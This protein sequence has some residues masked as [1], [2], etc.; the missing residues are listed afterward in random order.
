M[1]VYF[2]M[3]RP[4]NYDRAYEADL[5]SRLAPKIPE[6]VFDAHFHISRDEIP[7]VPDAEAFDTWKEYTNHFLGGNRI[8]GG[9]VMAHPKYYAEKETLDSHRLFACQLAQEHEGF[10]SGLVIRP[11]DDP[12]E[13][14]D[15]IRR[16]PRIVALKPYLTYSGAENIYEA[17]L[18]QYAPEWMWELASQY[19]LAMVLHLSHFGDGLSDPRNGEQLR[20]LCKKYPQVKVNL[21]HCAMGHNPD[22]LQQGLRYLDG[23][24]NLWTDVSGIGEAL[25]IICM[26]KYMGPERVMFASDGYRFAFHHHSRVF[27]LGGHFLS[28]SD[29]H[30]VDPSPLGLPTAYQFRPITPFAE[31]LSATVAACQ[32]CGLTEAQWQDVFYNNAAK[33]F[34][35]LVRE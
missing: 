10:V 23:L 5:L 14:D 26:L 21:A 16:F 9:L 31:N 28:F 18:L 19:R 17:D 11:Q 30:A 15:H 32:V 25:S 34:Y 3:E 12:R 4:A 8:R 20:Y 2:G 24:D 27:A 33:Q 29:R 13:M 7:N 6:Q 35:P 22:K 1:A